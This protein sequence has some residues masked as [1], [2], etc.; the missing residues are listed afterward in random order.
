MIFNC[1]TLL[2]W[3]M[4]TDWLG[5]AV[6]INPDTTDFYN[7]VEDGYEDVTEE[8]VKK[9]NAAWGDSEIQDSTITFTESPS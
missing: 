6:T 9:F 8:A 4:I 1:G 5:D 2:A 7:E 3:L